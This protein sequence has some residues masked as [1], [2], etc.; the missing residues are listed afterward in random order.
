MNKIF[1]A[2][3]EFKVDLTKSGKGRYALNGISLS[4]VTSITNM[5]AKGFLINWAASEAYKDC[6]TLPKDKIAEVLKSKQYAHTRKSDNAKDKGTLAHS[7]VEKFINDYIETKEYIFQTGLDEEVQTSVD[8]FFQWARDNKVEFLGS[9]VS[10]YSKKHFFAG[11]FDFVCKLDGKLLLGD[12]KTSK[13]IDDTY[14]AQGAAYAIAVEEN[15]PEIK[16]D[17]IIIVRSI[18]AKEGQ[19]WYEKSS[20]GSAKKIQNDAFEVGIKYTME[21]EKAYFLSLLNIYKYS[22]DLEVKRWYEA[23]EVPQYTDDDYPIDN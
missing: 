21:R 2:S 9:E 7:C 4:G 5:Q 13:Q 19:V 3:S 8:R 16:F 20:N 17:G 10:V 1:N 12:F 15:N 14:Y 11:T 6:L 18:L 23:P 22:K